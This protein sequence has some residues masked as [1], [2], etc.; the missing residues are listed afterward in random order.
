[1]RIHAICPVCEKTFATERMPRLVCPKCGSPFGFS[2]LQRKHL[3]VDKRTETKELALAE[4]DF[5]NAEFLGASLHYKK[6]LE[7]N[8][9]SYSAQYLYLLCELYLHE[10]ESDYDFMRNV[11]QM[12]DVTL[13]VMSRSVAPAQKKLAFIAA[14][15]G[16][17]KILV[18]RKLYSRDELLLIEPEEY[19][20]RTH[21]DLTAL[22]ELF[23]IDRERIMSFAQEIGSKLLEIAECAVKICYKTVQTVIIGEDLYP[24]S[25][26]AYARSG[27]LMNEFCFAAHVLDAEFD[28][29][30]YSPD[31][32]QN[33]LLND[34]VLTMFGKFDEKNVLN[35]NK[36]NTVYD[37]E[38]YSDILRE[39]EIAVRFTYLSCYKSLCSRQIKAH[40]DL[41][42]SGN[43]MLY[44]LLLPCVVVKPD[45][46]AEIHPVKFSDSVEYCDILTRF[47][48]DSYEL[49]P[50][51]GESLHEF[52][53]RLY[54][55]VNTYFV[56][57][58]DKIEKS[59]DMLKALGGKD[60]YDCQRLLYDGACSCVSALKKYFDF[61]AGPDKT[62][63]KLVKI[64]KRATEDFFILSGF[65]IEKLEKSKEFAP[66][67]KISTA[68]LEEEQ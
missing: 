30:N 12:V 49:N 57:E 60:F 54:S 64:C 31:F 42:Y 18:T 48:V 20:A 34:K 28:T 58:F 41:F 36:K 40:A 35:G 6:A 10:S 19:R 50:I 4:E 2:E 16:E 9:N 23:K 46:T 37:Y 7:A 44:R 17:V 63:E 56:S 43:E 5:K 59:T 65:D 26:E 66:I 61:S 1:M 62:R 47:V 14:M 21:A 13:T 33:H 15:L 11:V 45:K 32:T 67:L 68:L 25:D 53:E 29:A 22:T 38:E 24:P 55:L 3:I 51:V 39:C 27:A 8:K 52:Y